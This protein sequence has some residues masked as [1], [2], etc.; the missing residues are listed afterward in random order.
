MKKR[1]SSRQAWLVLALAA[2]LAIHYLP[3]GGLVAFPLMLFSTWAHEMGHGLTAIAVGG[4]IESLSLFA[5]G[6]GLARST[7]PEGWWREA[8]VSAGGLLG[9]P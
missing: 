2:I 8:L 7:F 3:M 1:E 6:S 9:P 5:D 4:K